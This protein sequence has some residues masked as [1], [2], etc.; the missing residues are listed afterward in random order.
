M[1]QNDIDALGKHIAENADG[2][3]FKK[4]TPATDRD[5]LATLEGKLRY[6]ADALEALGLSDAPDI[7]R[8]AASRLKSHAATI[9]ERD[10]T[11]ERM[12]DYAVHHANCDW[13]AG[14]L[15]DCGLSQL[16]EASQ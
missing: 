3:F 1:N 7:C 6:E 4:P 13:P 16:L 8:A 10:A 11:I 15:C 12:R 14:G 5:E 9:A 2:S